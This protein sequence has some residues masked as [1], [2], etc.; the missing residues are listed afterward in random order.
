MRIIAG[1]YR[2]RQLRVLEGFTTRPMPDRVKESVFGML[3]A[4]VEGAR[5]LDLFAGSG[6]LGLESL[7]RGAASCLFVE[8]D[9]AAAGVLEENIAALGCADR[10]TLALGDA[11][12]MSVVARAPEPTDLI[13]LDPPYPL[14]RTAAGWARVRAHATELAAKLAHDG[15]LLLR[16][17]WPFVL[18]AE[19]TPV[20]DTVPRGVRRSAKPRS[21]KRGP[22]RREWD[23]RLGEER[24]AGRPVHAGKPDDRG[25]GW[26]YRIDRDGP[27]WGEGTTGA[28]GDDGVRVVENRDSGPDG[29]A[30][31]AVAADMAI[32]GCRG[33]ETHAYGS[34][35]VHWYMRAGTPGGGA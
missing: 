32:A 26:V 5:V 1:Q 18:D 13:F 31:P 27:A 8:R 17:P 2:R 29:A 6:A 34:T 3:G 10:A 16:T 22:A 30:G 21:G 4:R 11:L 15:F 28:E 7:S 25:D 14:V 19:Q 23:A 35:A 20:G 33:P 24:G 12:G 9:R